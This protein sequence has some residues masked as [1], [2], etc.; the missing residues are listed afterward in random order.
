MK[1][2]YTFAKFCALQDRCMEVGM[3]YSPTIHPSHI[4]AMMDGHAI[5]VSF[6][7]FPNALIVPKTLPAREFI[8]WI[9]EAKRIANKERRK[10]KK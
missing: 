4:G 2:N 10:K 6:E 8:K 1:S 3:P 5:M 7:N 9:G